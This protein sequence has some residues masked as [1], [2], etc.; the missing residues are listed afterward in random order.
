MDPGFCRGDGLMIYQRLL[1]SNTSRNNPELHGNGIEDQVHSQVLEEA[2]RSVED[3]PPRAIDIKVSLGSNPALREV[4]HGG[5][6]ADIRCTPRSSK[7][8]STS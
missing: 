7:E 8:P 4:A 6:K 1:Q 5:E 2:A 3:I